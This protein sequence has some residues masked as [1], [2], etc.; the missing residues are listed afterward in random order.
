MNENKNTPVE[1]VPFKGSPLHVEMR[2]NE[3]FVKC[4]YAWTKQA[5]DADPSNMFWKDAWEFV[6]KRKKKLIINHNDKIKPIC[7][8]D[9]Q[10]EY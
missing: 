2:K 8:Q 4:V 10:Q 7:Q 3:V 1:S 9:T 6:Q 5:H